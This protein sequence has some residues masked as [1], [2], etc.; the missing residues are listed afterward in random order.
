M[1]LH[2]AC[3]KTLLTGKTDVLLG[4][5]P[6]TGSHWTPSPQLQTE[7]QL[8]PKCKAGQEPLQ[9]QTKAKSSLDVGKVHLVQTHE[10]W[11]KKK[12]KKSSKAAPCIGCLSYN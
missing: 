12:K 5:T 9:L 6:V 1:I 11:I 2:A 10:C 7:E 4:Q 3:F 8:R